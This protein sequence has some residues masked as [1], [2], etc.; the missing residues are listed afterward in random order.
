[1]HGGSAETGDDDAGPEDIH[2]HGY[3]LY[4]GVPHERVQISQETKFYHKQASSMVGNDRKQ[5]HPVGHEYFSSDYNV[6]IEENFKK[7]KTKIAGETRRKR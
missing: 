6:Y 4:E 2:S 7:I 5:G 1:M 3:K